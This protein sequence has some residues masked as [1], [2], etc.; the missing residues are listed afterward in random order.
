MKNVKIN[1][2]ETVTVALG[3]DAPDWTLKLSELSADMVAGI[4]N[5]GMRQVANDAAANYPKVVDGELTTKLD[6][7]AARQAKIE[8]GDY[9]FGAGGGGGSVAAHTVIMRTTIVAGLVKH[10]GLKKVE[11][12]KAA[13]AGLQAAFETGFVAMAIKADVTVTDE[14]LAEKY[15]GLETWARAQAAT[16]AAESG[17]DLS[18]V[19]ATVGDPGT[20]SDS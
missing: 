8:S 9:T 14:V 17:F 4:F 19:A 11:A 16:M 10:A 1:F 7:I 20:E 12:T 2:P 18:G 6:A 15:A 3:S 5:Y 13:V